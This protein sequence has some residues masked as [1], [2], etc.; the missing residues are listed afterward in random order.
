M[1]RIDHDSESIIKE[2]SEKLHSMESVCLKVATDIKN[3]DAETDLEKD[4]VKKE[5]IHFDKFKFLHHDK[6]IYKAK[7]FNLNSANM[8]EMEKMNIEFHEI[9]ELVEKVKDIE[10]EMQNKALDPKHVLK[11]EHE[12][13]SLALNELIHDNGNLQLVDESLEKQLESIDDSI[14]FFMKTEKD[15]HI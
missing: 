1:G 2:F 5:K 11:N 9:I 12:K 7:P 15:P 13:D 3:L 6:P 4:R 10:R 14:K 8:T